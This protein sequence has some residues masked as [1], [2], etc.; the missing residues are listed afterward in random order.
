MLSQAIEMS[1]K[2]K[3]K[4]RRI[5]A[6]VPEE[7]AVELEKWAAEET[8]SLSGLVTHLLVVAVSERQPQKPDRERQE[9]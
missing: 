1:P 6:Y 8:R 5:A 3:P 7:I 2:G 9:E 4:G